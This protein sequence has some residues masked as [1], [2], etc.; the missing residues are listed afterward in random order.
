MIAPHLN[1]STSYLPKC[2]FYYIIFIFNSIG[3]TLVAELLMLKTL[4]V[5]KK[6]VIFVLPYI[7]LVKEKEKYF[8][9]LVHLYNCSVDRRDRLRVKGFYGDQ[10]AMTCFKYDIL[11]CTIEKSNMVVNTLVRQGYSHKLGCVIID[12]MH[13]LGDRDR[14]YHLE[15]L[16]RYIYI[17]I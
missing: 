13:V 4:L 17:Y 12:E 2:M 5:L 1:L 11:V 16:I 6:K 9:K 8:S 10:G 7:S 14:G 15:I 3:K